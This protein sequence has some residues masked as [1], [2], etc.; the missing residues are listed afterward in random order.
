MI[1]Y[2]NNNYLSISA[3]SEDNKCRCG[4]NYAAHTYE[5]MD[6]GKPC[7]CF[8]C[9]ECG[10]DQNGNFECEGFCRVG[11]LP[12]EFRARIKA[13][14]EARKKAQDDARKKVQDDARK[15]EKERLEKEQKEKERL[16]KEQ[17][18]KEQYRNFN[19]FHICDI[20]NLSSIIEK[21]LFSRVLVKT[22]C[23]EFVDIANVDIVSKRRGKWITFASTYFEPINAMYYAVRR[24]YETVIVE[25]ELDL[26]KPGIV[27]TDGNAATGRPTVTNFHHSNF[28]EIMESLK[29]LWQVR[30]RGPDNFESTDEF[31]EQRR[32]YQAECLVPENISR[33]CIKSIQIAGEIN[34]SDIISHVDDLIAKSGFSI[35]RK[36]MYYSP[37]KVRRE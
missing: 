27:I 36:I 22:K 23:P 11:S 20:K 34:Y 13:E 19:L 26:S 18:E 35:K 5:K 16:E 15:K 17:L 14:N 10:K 4:H 12:P 31:Q 9:K 6:T 7:D 24:Q 37:P 21:G 3:M 33:D 25:F 8:H 2:F 29:K 32:M 28:V 1:Y 30:Y